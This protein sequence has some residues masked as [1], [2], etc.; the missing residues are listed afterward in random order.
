MAGRSRDTPCTIHRFLTLNA[1]RKSKR[2]TKDIWRTW[3]RA[4]RTLRLD[5]H[6]TKR[7]SLAS[8]QL[9]RA[10]D[11]LVPTQAIPNPFTE[12]CSHPTRVAWNP[13]DTLDQP[14]CQEIID[15]VPLYATLQSLRED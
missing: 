1:S 15:S 3:R 4:P 13:E 14:D 2:P 6:G 9:R 7:T 5:G 8:T 10:G 12:E 11:R